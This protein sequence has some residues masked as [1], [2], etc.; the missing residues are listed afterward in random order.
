MTLVFRSVAS[1]LVASF[2]TGHLLDHLGEQTENYEDRHK[3]S[4][5]ED[6]NVVHEVLLGEEP[7]NPS[8]KIDGTQRP[9][10]IPVSLLPGPRRPNHSETENTN[11]KNAAAKMNMSDLL[12]FIKPKNKALNFK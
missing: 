8:A 12:S 3:Y 5:A 7:Y 6:H 2:R 1:D 9:T 4:D 10:K 11:E